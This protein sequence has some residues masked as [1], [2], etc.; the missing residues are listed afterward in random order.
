MK[1]YVWRH[2]KKFSSW[3]M[4]DE[5][6]IFKDNYMQAEVVI[7]ATSKEEALEMLKSDD[8]WNIDEL[9]R[10]E[11]MVF[12]LDRPAVISKLVSFS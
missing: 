11:P 5:P 12:D 3:S 8:R 7:L 10:I 1:I 4:F 9:Q 2:S 6:H